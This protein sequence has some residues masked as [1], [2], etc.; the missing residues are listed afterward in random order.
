[1]NTKYVYFVVLFVVFSAW[2]STSTVK[3][4]VKT[5]SQEE[6]KEIVQSII[7]TDPAL[8]GIKIGDFQ[9]SG[10]CNIEYINDKP[11]NTSVQSIAKDSDLKLTGWAMDVGKLLLPDQVVVHF[12]NAENVEETNYYS[13]AN[14][15]LERS[16]VMEYF[17]LKDQVN[18]SGFELHTNIKNVS[19]GVYALILVVNYEGDS[20]VC[21]NSRVIEVK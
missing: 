13:L 17:K 11:M 5:K 20:Y 14:S 1:M 18:A 8:L 9:K 15:G 4:S 16:D 21:D 6:T 12:I 19:I 2:F 10:D 3:P 7:V